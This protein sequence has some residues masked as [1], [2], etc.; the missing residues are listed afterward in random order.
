[1]FA[2]LFISFPFTDLP[3]TTGLTA[4][5][6]SQSLGAALSVVRYTLSVVRC[7]LHVACMLAVHV[8]VVVRLVL[9]SRNRCSQSHLQLHCQLPIAIVV[10][11]VGTSLAP[12]GDNTNNNSVQRLEHIVKLIYNMMSPWH[13]HRQSVID[14]SSQS[15]SNNNRS[16][17]HTDTMQ[18]LYIGGNVGASWLNKAIQKCLMRDMQDKEVSW[19]CRL[20]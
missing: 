19:A 14:S 20:L 2:W 17:V 15:Q 18:T 10:I 7:P 16:A 1:M 12:P 11:V 8:A 4:W 6:A 9:S 5:T 3:E 13:K